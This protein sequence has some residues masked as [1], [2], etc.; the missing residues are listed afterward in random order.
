MTSSRVPTKGKSPM[1]R[2]ILLASLSSILLLSGAGCDDRDAEIQKRITDAHDDALTLK[3]DIDELKDHLD[4]LTAQTDN[5]QS[6]VDRFSDGPT[7]WRE[8]VPHI[9]S[10]T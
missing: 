8:V 6:D 10:K 7:N 5:L 2:Y 9:E 4:Q 1:R 3:S